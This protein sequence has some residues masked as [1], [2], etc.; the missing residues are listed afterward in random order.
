MDQ[1][2][3][4][5]LWRDKWINEAGMGPQVT[6]IAWLLDNG[7]TD[8]DDDE[9][10]KRRRWNARNYDELGTYL[11]RKNVYRILWG[12]VFEDGHLEDRERYGTITLRWIT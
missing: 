9:F 5:D 6:P 2:S 3:S 7:D 12:N 1:G 8:V 4:E 10:K 11:Y